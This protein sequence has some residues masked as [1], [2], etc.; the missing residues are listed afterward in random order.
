M[1][2]DYVTKF[3]YGPIYNNNGNMLPAAEVY[4]VRYAANWLREDGSIER[5][6][7]INTK[8]T[9]TYFYTLKSTIIPG[10]G[11]D[12]LAFGVSETD[13][14]KGGYCLLRWEENTRKEESIY[15]PEFSNLNYSYTVDERGWMEITAPAVDPGQPGADE[16]TCTYTLRKEENGPAVK[17]LTLAPG[18]TG[19]IEGLEEGS[20]LLMETVNMDLSDGFT[21]AISGDPFG[22][23]EVEKD[24]KLTVMGDRT[25]TISKPAGSDNGR[26]YTFRITRDGSGAFEPQTV[27]LQAGQNSGAKSGENPN[28]TDQSI[29]LPAGNYTVTP[30]DDHAEVFEL[31]CSDSSQVHAEVPSS[32]SATVTFTN[33]FTPGELGCRYVHEYCP[34]KDGKYIY[35]GSSP[36]TTVGGR[37]DAA[38]A[39]SSV[40]ITKEPD[41]TFTDDKGERQTHTYA[42]IPQKN[43]YG[44]VSQTAPGGGT[45]D[46][47]GFRLVGR[48]TVPISSITRWTA[49]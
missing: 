5:E 10:T 49:S 27:F 42:Y 28:G 44:Y 46:A 9:G 43:G 48:G 17:T 37:S 26:T 2:G 23:T 40:D 25:L 30:T 20:Y 14:N 31:T 7:F 38:E 24:F 32:S 39:Y 8:A 11:A 15:T 22:S 29:T 1:S 6:G 13:A 4:T 34:L 41:Y 3:R 35:K 19:R 45:E 12:R 36:I 16:I 33:V 18:T 47:E 21:M